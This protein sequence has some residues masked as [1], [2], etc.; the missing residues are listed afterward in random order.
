MKVADIFNP[1][2]RKNLTQMSKFKTVFPSTETIFSKDIVI[3]EEPN[4]I[5]NYVK[6]KFQDDQSFYE[7]SNYTKNDIEYVLVREK[8]YKNIKYK[9]FYECKF[10]KI[11]ELSPERVTSASDNTTTNSNSGDKKHLYRK[12][13]KSRFDFVSDKINLENEIPDFISDMLYRKISRFTF[14]KK[15]ISNKNDVN[16]FER[17]LKFNNSWAQ[18]IKS[19][20]GI[21]E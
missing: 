9:N 19:N 5:K 16:F 18:F 8:P 15:F 17:E 13:D 3:Q 20:I 6:K 1:D 10:V 11:K 21:E 12:R 4:K 7:C 2:V 14:F